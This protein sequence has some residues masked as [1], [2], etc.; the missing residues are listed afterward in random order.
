MKT[1]FMLIV[2]IVFGI[3]SVI[4]PTDFRSKIENPEPTSTPQPTNKIFPTTEPVP[5]VLDNEE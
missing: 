5:V 3:G 1:L 4:S 2:S